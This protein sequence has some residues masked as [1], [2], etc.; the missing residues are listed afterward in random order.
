MQILIGC[1]NCPIILIIILT[2]AFRSVACIVCRGI[3]VLVRH[4]R[5][6]GSLNGKLGQLEEPGPGL[7]GKDRIHSI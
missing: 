5:P 6:L 7:R 1:S 3:T 2:H 4:Q